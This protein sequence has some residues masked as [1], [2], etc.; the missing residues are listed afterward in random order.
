MTKKIDALPNGIVWDLDNTLYTVTPA[1]EAVYNRAF[2]NAIIDHGIDIT[3]EEAY[4]LADEGWKKYKSSM[5]LF[6]EK[7]NLQWQDLHFKILPHLD[8]SKI[9]SC[10][11]TQDL[12]A[13]CDAAHSLITHSTRH[14]AHAVL[15]HIGLK[16]W[17]ADEC[18][19]GF[20][21]YDFHNKAKS[22]KPFETALSALDQN[23]KDCLMVEDTLI[24]LAIPKDMGM[25]TIYLH[26]GRTPEEIPDYVDLC[27]KD[28][29]EMMETLY[30]KASG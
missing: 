21:C 12:F 6:V 2:A 16:K 22:T 14:W 1:L 9:E 3:H 19:F 28:V 25:T 8:H 15:N 27:F 23:A 18:V 20:E 11:Q 10:T 4:R 30:S 7:Y 26:Q 24:N 29:R 5:A 13:Q 17:F